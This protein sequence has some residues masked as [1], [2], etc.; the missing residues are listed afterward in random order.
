MYNLGTV[1]QFEV[2]RSLKKKSFWIMALALPMI[3]SLIFGIIF[4]SNQ[5]TEKAAE[6]TNKQKFSFVISDD[7]SLI[8][9]ELL[10]AFG[11]SQT[12]DRLAAI[13]DVKN[14]KIDALFYYPA[15]LS[16]DSVEVYARDVGLFN[17]GRYQAVAKILI[18]QSIS[19]TVDSATTAILQDTVKYNSTTYRNGVKFNG[20]QE[21]IAPGIFLIL[22]Y[23]L[24]AM[25]G[26][27][28]LTSTTEE[29]E[30]RITEMILTT[31]EARTLIIGKILSLIVLAFIQVLIIL[32][33][34]IIAYLLFRQQLAFPDIDFSSIPLNP[35]PI[36]LGALIFAASFMLFT[37]ILV[38]VGAIAPTAKEA[39]S[40]F[41]VI[42]IFIFGPLYAAPLFVSSPDSLIVKLLSFFPL[43]APIPL[44]L[45]NAVGNLSLV[46]SLIGIAILTASAIIVL[47]IA[48]R[49]FK[50]GV[51]AYSNRLK[52][53]N[54]FERKK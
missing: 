2:I 53:N 21:L 41:G 40:F 45:R 29:K 1:F 3:I 35:L 20:F 10:T 19:P 17:N 30:N 47:T 12:N 49:L 4:L 24:I 28:M 26:N 43:T 32:I 38:T 44:L 42:M 51:L 23:F 14:D 6:Y 37:G 11:A 33:P 36:T 54:L 15:D 16:K 50:Y 46:D 22:F 9:N 7:S 48:I 31:I 34:V 13:E 25:F 8:N 5:A 27:Q 39:G 18:Q 52:L